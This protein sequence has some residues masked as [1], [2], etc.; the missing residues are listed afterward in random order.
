MAGQLL[1][2]DLVCCDQAILRPWCYIWPMPAAPSPKFVPKK[3]AFASVLKPVQDTRMWQKMGR[4]ALASGRYEVLVVGAGAAP[5]SG[6][7]GAS[8]YPIFGG[9]RLG[10]W[11]YFVSLKYAQFLWSH[12]PDIQ[13]VCSPELLFVACLYRGLFR[14]SRLVYDVRENYIAN[15]WFTDG[16]NVLIRPIL[17]A[18]ISVLERLATLVADQIWVAEACYQEERPSYFGKSILLPNLYDHGLGFRTEPPENQDP[19][20]PLQLLISGT[21]GRHYGTLEAITWAKKLAAIRT[22]KL[23]ISGYAAD[24][25]YSKLVMEA[26]QGID[27][28]ITEGITS[29]VP[30]S[31]II[32][33]TKETD[34]LLLPYLPN[35]STQNRIPTKLYEGLAW[36]VPMLVSYNGVWAALIKNHDAGLVLDFNQTPTPDLVNQLDTHPFYR[37]GLD[38]NLDPIFWQSIEPKFLDSLDALIP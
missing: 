11:R 6:P 2:T 1:A 31:R 30:Y 36:F 35:R 32:E 13:V 23:T 26:C 16:Y 12:R 7:K 22:I 19:D 20:K 37:R 3:I 33:L 9:S 21:L 15:I 29:M 8:F 18:Y 34:F 25:E 17:A 27:W 5:A 28:I 24:L 10:I 4:S 38:I 14:S